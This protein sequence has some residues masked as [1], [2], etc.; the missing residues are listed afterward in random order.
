[1]LELLIARLHA[2][3]SLMRDISVVTARYD[4]NAGR[5]AVARELLELAK[6]IAHLGRLLLDSDG[7]DNDQTEA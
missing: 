3:D 7:G 2:D 4:S 6:Q 1:V 5:P